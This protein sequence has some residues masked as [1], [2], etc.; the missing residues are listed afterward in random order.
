MPTQEVQIQ[1]LLKKFQLLVKKHQ[2][3]E[4]ENL[5][6]TKEVNELKEKLLTSKKDTEIVEMQNAILKAGS[7]Q[8]DDKEKKEM[9]KKLNFYIAEIDRCIALISR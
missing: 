1:N 7:Q 5:R 2:S 8:L 3:I 4:K 9:E 6:L